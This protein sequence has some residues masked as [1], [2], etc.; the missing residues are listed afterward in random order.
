MNAKISPDGTS[1][2]SVT[3]LPPDYFNDKNSVKYRFTTLKD[4]A[5]SGT[6]RPIPYEDSHQDEILGY[7]DKYKDFTL[8]VHF[9]WCLE[10]CSYC[11]YYHGPMLKSQEIER[12]MAA[13]RQHLKMLDEVVDLS[14]KN[15]RSIYFGGGTPTVIP[16][17]LLA[18]AFEFYS[19]R[20]GKDEECEFCV[21]TSIYTL[22]PPKIALMKK[23][24]NRLSVGVQSFNDRI[25]KILE[26]QHTGAQAVEMLQ[27]I[28]PHFN[29][30]NI[31]LVYGL[32]DQSIEDWLETIQIAIDVKVPSINIYRL[33]LREK[34]NLIR[35][36]RESP[37]K[38]PDEILPWCMYNEAK[39]ILERAG[40]REN[41]I[42]WFLLPQVKDTTVYRER[43][44]KQ[45]PCIALGP[46][47][48][49]FAADHFYETI[50]EHHNYCTAVENG[51]FPIKHIAR[52]TPDRQLV[53]YVLSQLKSN[54][55]VY[56]SVIEQRFG[57]EH[58]NGFMNRISNYLQWNV[59]T[60]SGDKIEIS[61]E[62]HYLLEWVLQELVSTIP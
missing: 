48:H 31:D 9:P 1:Y 11:H 23:Y 36:Y 30:V 12:L 18:E 8:Y 35:A 28:I 42:G 60:Q 43:W 21:E 55:P 15:V 20:Y 39:Q 33:D 40:Y 54:S 41:L 24:V 56:K 58:L 27:E 19:G 17:D 47:L 44:E 59:L 16:A 50:Q 7:Y 57:S 34:P 61:K 37:E 25:L 46:G 5:M 53:G 10:H 2:N 45:T 32:C 4:V 52:M 49:N 13:E 14:A 22:R 26:R 3:K 51:I 6:P 29:N 38:F 62:S